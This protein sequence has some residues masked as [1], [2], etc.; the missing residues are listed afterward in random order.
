MPANAWGVYFGR[1]DGISIDNLPALL[2]EDSDYAHASYQRLKDLSVGDLVEMVHAYGER[3][4]VREQRRFFISAWP[5]FILVDYGAPEYFEALVDA[6]T[7]R[8]NR[9]IYL[10]V[11]EGREFYVG[12][13]INRESSSLEWPEMTVML[14]E[15]GNVR[16]RPLDLL[17]P[18]HDG[19]PHVWDAHFLYPHPGLSVADACRY[20]EDVRSFVES[21]EAGSMSRDALATAL[22]TGHAE[23]LIGLAEHQMLDVK[24]PPD[25]SERV[26]QLELAKDIAAFANSMVGGLLVIGA[27]TKSVDGKDIVKRLCPLSDATTIIQRANSIL[28]TRIYPPLAGVEAQAIATR[29]GEQLVMIN[30]PPQPDELKPFIV[31]GANIGHKLRDIFVS[32]PQR[33]G[34]HSTILSPAALHARLVVGRAWLERRRVD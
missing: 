22:R 10:I 27:E 8:P 21:F 1:N 15:W 19:L 11:T 4:E 6:Q 28:E 29:S 20:A 9:G 7:V 33:E 2:Y 25:L 5:L 18:T 30:V 16:G 17:A 26:A 14:R 31:H 34:D 32:I 12:V 3:P 24:R 23:V 13:T